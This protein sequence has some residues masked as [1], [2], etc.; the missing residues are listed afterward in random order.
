MAMPLLHLTDGSTSVSLNGGPVWTTNYPM[1]SAGS[2]VE[3]ASDRLTD[4]LELVFTG[5]TEAAVQTSMRAVESLLDAAR[6]R[7]LYGVG[8]RVYL[9]AQIGSDGDAWRSEV[10]EGVL[11]SEAGPGQLWRKA[12]EAQLSVTRRPWWDGPESEVPISASGFGAATGGRTITNNGTANWIQADASAVGGVLPTPARLS[13][14]NTTGSSKSYRSVWAG[15]NALAPNNTLGATLYQGEG[16]VAGYGTAISDSGASGGQYLRM[17]APTTQAVGA[18]WAL[19]ASLMEAGGRRFRLLARFTNYNAVYK[20]KVQ[21]A[22]YDGAGVYRLWLGE[23]TLLASAGASPIV[24][25]GSVPLPPGAVDTGYAAVRLALLLRADTAITVGVDYLQF[26]GQDGFR[27]MQNA[28]PALASNEYV[29]IDDIDGR[30][31]LT[32]SGDLTPALAA[33]GK[34]LLLY[35]NQTQRINVLHT[36]SLEASPT[37]ETW[38]ARLYYRPRR[39]SL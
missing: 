37:T 18:M 5:T 24:D 17:D 3:N 2:A 39:P 10:L 14:R 26:V 25:L 30:H 22:V 6:R 9:T 34:S 29:Q 38:S 8:P 35:P 7:Q 16:R 4:S 36:N 21:P 15:V 23:E 19:S 1:Q 27:E 13:L 33:R 12:V 31:G 32:S 11:L 20:P 28:G